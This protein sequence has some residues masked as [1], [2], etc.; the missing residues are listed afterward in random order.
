MLEGSFHLACLCG[1]PRDLLDHAGSHSS[2]FILLT[3]LGKEALE[4]AEIG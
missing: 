3:T 2:E 1:R 4:I